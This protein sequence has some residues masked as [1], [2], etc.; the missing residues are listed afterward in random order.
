MSLAWSTLVRALAVSA[1]VLA[2]AVVAAT[3]AQPHPN[4]ATSIPGEALFVISGRGYGHGVGMGQYGAFGQANAGRSHEQILTHYY[5]GTEIGRAPKR[6]VRVLLAEGRRAVVLSSTTPYTL[7]DA[8]G[9]VFKLPPGPLSIRPGL[10]LPTPEGLERAVFPVTARP[11]KGILDA[12]RRPV[13]R[14]A[15]GGAPGRLPAHRQRDAARELH[16][17]RRRERDAAHMAVGGAPGTGGRRALV[18]AR[19]PRRGQAVRPVLRPAEPGV[20]GRRGRDGENLRGGARDR[21]RGPAPRRQGRDDLLLLEL[22]RQDG[23][24]GRCLRLAGR[25][26]RLAPRPVGQGLAVAQLGA[27]PLRRTHPP[28]EVR[29]RRTACWMRPACRRRRGGSAPSRCTL[30][31]GP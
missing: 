1:V 17:R 29:C 28:V 2:L 7:V 18:R 8:K 22:G 3:P 13:P 15:R 21:P 25:V 24:R 31:A 11:G 5:A 23:E 16:R 20:R 6:Q 19:E 14:Q 9:T 27:D 10:R 12:R 30:Q 4:Q 26:P